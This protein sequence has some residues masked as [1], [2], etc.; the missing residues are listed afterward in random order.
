MSKDIIKEQKLDEE[1]QELLEAF[2][3][4]ELKSVDNLAEEL[5]F[6]REAAANYFRK[7]ARINIRL[8]RSDLNRI[9]QKAAY[10]GLPYQTLIASLL[11]KY[12]A[13]H[14]QAGHID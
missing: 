10:E 5:A 2:E 8:S 12:A 4:G 9:K 7:D 11:H 6:A 13:G 14:L 3:R 1:E